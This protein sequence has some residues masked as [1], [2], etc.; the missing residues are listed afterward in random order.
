MPLSPRRVR[1]EEISSARQATMRCP[2]R[3]KTSGTIGS[4]RSSFSAGM[5]TTTKSRFEQSLFARVFVKP[6]GH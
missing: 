2:T 4:E 5:I 3:G 1:Q 6:I